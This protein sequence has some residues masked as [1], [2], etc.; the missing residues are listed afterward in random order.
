MIEMIELI[1]FLGKSIMFMLMV[2]A[3]ELAVIMWHVYAHDRNF[4]EIMEKISNQLE[5]QLEN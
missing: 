5:D 3:F 2:I 1:G 4:S